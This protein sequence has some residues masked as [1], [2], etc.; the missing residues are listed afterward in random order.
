MKE[1]E[2]YTNA[3]SLKIIFR[4]VNGNEKIIEKQNIKNIKM[5]I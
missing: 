1:K 3:C 2:K 4:K 5:K